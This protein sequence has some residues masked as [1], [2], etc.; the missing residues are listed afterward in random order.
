MCIVTG[1]S[2]GI[3]LEGVFIHKFISRT[4]ISLT[5]AMCISLTSILPI[6]TFPTCILGTLRELILILPMSGITTLYH[7]YNSK[8]S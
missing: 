2:G 8:E 5:F 6:P 7:L 1:T 4:P 3:A